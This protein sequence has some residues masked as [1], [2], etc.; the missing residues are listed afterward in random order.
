VLGSF[1]GAPPGHEGRFYRITMPP[2]PGAGVPE[3]PVPIYL[4]AVNEKMA[5]T[6]GRVADGISGHPMNSTEYLS[7]VVVPA[8]ER[9]AESA[10]RDMSEIS[11]TTNLITQVA[12]DGADAK[13]LASVQLA[14]YAT[15]RS[16]APVLAMHGFEDLV[17]P[18][19]EAHGRG[20]FG[21][22]SELA[23]P[24]VDTLTAAGTPDEVRDRVQSFE[25]IADRVILGGSWVS[26]SPER[27]NENFELLLETFGS[28]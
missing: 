28:G 12:K 10:G 22:M 19:R 9:G 25:G 6:A 5:E 14:F 7:K 13:Q 8:I 23:A 2:F 18:I 27:A 21:A 20:D 11:V 1:E 17:A 3:S 26:A 15:T 16:Y 4:A 24:M